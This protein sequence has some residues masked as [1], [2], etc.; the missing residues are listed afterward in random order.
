MLTL[1]TNTIHTYFNYFIFIMDYSNFRI[2]TILI[3][4]L[5][6]TSCGGGGGGG[7]AASAAPLANITFTTSFGDEVDVG[8]DFSFSWSTSNAISCSASGD[9]SGSVGVSGS[10][11]KN[12]DTPGQYSFTL[13][14]SNSESKETSKTLSVTANYVIIKGNIFDS[15]NSGKTVYIDQNFNNIN[16]SNEPSAISND[17]GYYEIRYI[18]E[19]SCLNDLPVKVTN[20]NLGSINPPGFSEVNISATTS[21]FLN[22]AIDPLWDFGSNTCDSSNVYWDKFKEQ[23]FNEDMAG[24]SEYDQYD[25]SEIQADPSSSNR[26]SISLDRFDD[27][28]TFNSSLESV[29]SSLIDVI[30]SQINSV[31]L[32]STDFEFNISSSLLD[33]NLRIFLNDNSY[34]NPSTDQSPV[35]SGI[36]AVSA[37]ASISIAI[38]NVNAVPGYDVN[39]WDDKVF[40]YMPDLLINNSN[41]VISDTSNCWINFTSLCI[42]DINFDLI[43]LNETGVISISNMRKNT[44]RGLEEYNW[45][46]YFYPGSYVCNVFAEAIISEEHDFGPPKETV[47]SNQHWP[48]YPNSNDGIAYCQ[49]YTGSVY[50]YMTHYV[51]FDDGSYIFFEWDTNQIDNL[52]DIV[53]S[54][55][56]DEVDPPP[57]AIPQDIVNLMTERPNLYDLYP[58]FDITYPDGSMDNW[59]IMM[60]WFYEMIA[61]THNINSSE[62]YWFSMYIRNTSGG[63]ARILA[64]NENGY[65]YAECQLNGNAI[66]NSTAYG[67]DTDAVMNGF[68]V[69]ILAFDDGLGNSLMSRKSTVTSDYQHCSPYS[70]CISTTASNSSYTINRE[71]PEINYKEIPEAIDS[72]NGHGPFSSRLDRRASRDKDWSHLSDSN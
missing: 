10:H 15:N 30:K 13:R 17:N 21:L 7:S 25:Y 32:N 61:V 29:S 34:P 36:D 1:C 55:W 50:K 12:L 4:S 65:P 20:S 42:Q 22:F 68:N 66:F 19:S 41:Q 8:T 47:Y 3:F 43:N 33:A 70:G 18:N 49:Y 27:I 67:Y 31:G 62:L 44:S 26:A 6:M 54:G 35:A 56:Y 52:Q 48:S 23:R 24:I 5:V 57:D 45:E 9:W 16:D 59:T 51:P 71:I 14:C 28:K 53:E 2:L 46:E 11:Q 38:D 40:L 64:H 58:E 63:L 69:C 60:N 37:Q 72:L 39:G